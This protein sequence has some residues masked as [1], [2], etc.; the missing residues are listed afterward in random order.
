VFLFATKPANS[1]RQGAG[2]RR[3]PLNLPD[4]LLFLHSS[5]RIRAVHAPCW[6]T[7]RAPPPIRT[8]RLPTKVTSVAGY[9]HA[10][11]SP[12]HRRLIFFQTV[13]DSRSLNG[14]NKNR[15][16][17]AIVIPLLPESLASFR[18]SRCTCC[19]LGLFAGLTSALRAH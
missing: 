8:I 17:P 18:N 1:R 7:P 4:S 6:P 9:L 13:S 19:S 12:Q 10:V 2:T 11:A 15:R 5:R 3:R 14:S 16:S